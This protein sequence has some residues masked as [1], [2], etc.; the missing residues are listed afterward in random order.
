MEKVPHLVQLEGKH[1][2]LDKVIVPHKLRQLLL[3]FTLSNATFLLP[4]LHLKRAVRPELDRGVAS[5]RDHPE[6]L[7]R[8][9]LLLILLT[10]TIC[11]CTNSSKFQEVHRPDFLLVHFERVLALLLAIVPNLDDTVNAGCGDLE[12]GVQ[13]C[14]FDQGLCM[15]L[16]GR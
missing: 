13:P 16:Q 5:T 7:P 3:F 9:L 11:C 2:G 15:S 10:L 4:H 12:P 1:R 6:C 14:C 8:L